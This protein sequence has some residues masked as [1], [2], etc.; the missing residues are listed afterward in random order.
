LGPQ[1][2]G[3][4]GKIDLHRTV[5]FSMRWKWFVQQLFGGLHPIPGASALVKQAGHDTASLCGAS[6]T[7]FQSLLG[8][9]P[10]LVYRGLINPKLCQEST[11]I[12]LEG[13]FA[14][15]RLGQDP[16]APAS[17][18]TKI[19]YTK[20]DVLIQEGFRMTATSAAPE[21]YISSALETTKL[22]QKALGGDF[23][24][25]LASKFAPLGISLQLEQ[26]PL[27]QRPFLPC[28]VRRME[29]GGRRKEGNIHMDT[30]VPGSTLSLNVYLNVPE[31]SGGELVLYPIR[32]D[33]LQR[34]LNS[35]FFETIDLQNFFPDK[36]FY[37]KEMLK[38]VEPIVY[39]PAT[40]DVVFIDPAYPHAVRDFV[41]SEKSVGPTSRLSLQTF[42]QV[43]GS[44]EGN[45]ELR[46]EYAV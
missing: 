45:E 20:T 10:V 44:L 33:S 18:Y 31:M 34:F 28:V 39:S 30:V 13:R 3:H 6:R 46:L 38:E 37:T 24:H 14:E 27:S 12:L 43:S 23:F 8:A 9:C 21:K 19:G 32:K 7:D 11:Q 22:L 4:G 5:P 16:D 25:A 41:V 17:D 1:S 35:H 36:E 29:P 40:G 2:L 26:C 42:M 15:W